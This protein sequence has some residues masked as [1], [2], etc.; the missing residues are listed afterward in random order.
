[1]KMTQVIRRAGVGILAVAISSGD[2]SAQPTTDFDDLVPALMREYSVPGAA[3]VIVT[4]DSVAYLGGFGLARVADDIS[5]D[6]ERTTFRIASVAKL[7]VAT[8][9]AVMAERGLVSLD[10]DIREIAP[11]VPLHGDR[12]I[13][14]HHLLT[15]TGGFDERL[16]G[17]AATSR[18]GILPLGEYLASNMPPLGWA[19]GE[20]VG[21]SNHGMAL[22]A[23]VLEREADVPFARLAH[24][25]LFAP[26]GMQRTSYR[27]RLDSIA[28]FAAVGHRC[29]NGRCEPVAEVFSHPYPVGLAYATAADM[30]RFLT[31]H[32]NGGIVDGQQVL[33]ATAIQSMQREQFRHDR[34]LPGMSYGFF[35]QDVGGRRALAH[36]GRVPGTSSLLLILPDSRLGFFFAANGGGQGFGRALRDSILARLAPP[37]ARPESTE[38]M[39][40]PDPMNV[41]DMAGAYLLTRYAHSTI[42]RF[43]MLFGMATIV[44]S[45]DGRL[46]LA[47]GGGRVR[48]SPLDSLAFREVDGTRMVAFRKDATGNVTHMFAPVEVFGAEMPGAY[49]RLAW[50]DEPR[51]KNE[52][53]SFLMGIPLIVLFALWPVAS[54]GGWWWRRRRNAATQ[55][56]RWPGGWLALGAANGFFVLF[57]VFGFGFIARSV[58]MFEQTRGIVYGMTDDM[59]LLAVVP[60]LLVPLGLI[61]L[62]STWRAWRR[63]RWGVVRR[64]YYTLLAAGV[65]LVL[66][67]LVRW[68]YLPPRW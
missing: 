26:L 51:F 55:S 13:T 39:R 57:A 29:R 19:P 5:V 17:Y 41:E 65:V 8:T 31:A 40:T 67:F 54:L 62:G 33:P 27:D 59:K 7:F 10:A 18:E 56:G 45:R 60:Y 30:G 2:L 66:A 14:L 12:S 36:A 28:E 50:Y 32:L 16:I 46:S 24:D 61:V 35:N 49:E 1:M 25:V 38:T 63:P 4:G 23:Y 3:L 37:I 68:N 64:G 21:Y 43:P 48:F 34:R 52:Y 58:R 11:S 44:T 42:E 20:L 53:L 6:P 15:H 9:A 22:A 47:L